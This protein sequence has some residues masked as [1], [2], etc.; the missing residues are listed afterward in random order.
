MTP[1]QIDFG[2]WDHFERAPDTP[3]SEQYRQKIA[4]IQEAER[5]GYRHYHIAEHHLTPLDLAPSPSVFLAALAQA[6]SRIR[7]GTGVYCLPLYHPVRLVQELSMLDNIAGG[8]LDIGIGRGIR[9]TEH[10]WFGVPAEEVQ[11]R[12]EETLEV[13]VQGMST[14]CIDHHGR[15]YDFDDLSLDVVPLQQPHPPLWY[16]GGAETAGRN[17]FNF[18]GRN[19]ED[20]RRYWQLRTETNGAAPR[21]NAHVETPAVA[22]TRHVVIR[23]NAAEAE[24]IARRSWPVYESHF[25]ATSVLL[26]RD[27]G[28]APLQ[29]ERSANLDRMLRDDG[30]LIAGTPAM[31]S[32]HLQRWADDL[33]DTP[34]FTFAPALQWGD[35]DHKEAMETLRLVAQVMDELQPE[36]SRAV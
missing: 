16:A 10:A 13:I 24:A 32:D 26:N 30:R 14:G 20:A 6:T 8:R 36:R 11:G 17:G 18:L 3:V 12:F 23:E 15:H 4:L 21:Y 5:L 34:G 31:L 29:R 19:P 25:F 28:T 35:I 9:A 27:G 33:K 7:L 22:L 1:M 2:L